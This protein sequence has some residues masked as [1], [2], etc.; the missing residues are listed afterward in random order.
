MST[1]A[2]VQ[3][4]AEAHGWSLT[5]A[6]TDDGGVRFEF[7]AGTASRAGSVTGDTVGGE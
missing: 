4:I 6:N 3:Q 5:I 7:G 1:V 2:I